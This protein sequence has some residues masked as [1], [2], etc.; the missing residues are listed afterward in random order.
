[1]QQR[2]WMV[3]GLC[4][5]L[6]GCAAMPA[7]EAVPEGQPIDAFVDGLKADLARV[8]WRVRSDRPACGN[9]GAREIDLRDAE[10]V[11]TLKRTAQASIGGDVRLVALPLG[12]VGVEPLLSAGYSR[13]DSGTLVIKLAV[14]GP[15]PLHVHGERADGDGPV[16][17]TLN[18]AI[19]GFMHSQA[20]APCVHLR[21]LK[22]TLVLDIERNAGGGFRITVPA[23]K[24]NGELAAQAVNTLTL[25]WAHVAS[26]GL[27]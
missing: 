22:L 18:A 10:V 21:A 14:D 27:R 3:A 17:R 16:A 6:G 9:L 12:N 13:A 7:G 4:L 1:M 5:A 2:L 23:V 20:R 11:L 25:E 24:V 8:H 15:V 19:D 26:N